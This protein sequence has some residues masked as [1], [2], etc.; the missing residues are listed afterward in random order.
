[1]LKRDPDPQG[2]NERTLE[3]LR[4]IIRSVEMYSKRLSSSHNITGPQLSCLLTIGKHQPLTA[5]R[6][7]KTVHVSASTL[8]GVLDRLEE[9]GL[10]VRRRDATDR[11][12]VYISLSDKGEEVSREAPPPLQEKLAQALLAASELEQCAIALA[13]EKIVQVMEV[14]EVQA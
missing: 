2:Y 7:A 5:S 6:I 12:R 4:R 11:R 3:S 13:L 9:K 8:V 10:I 14:Q 1:M